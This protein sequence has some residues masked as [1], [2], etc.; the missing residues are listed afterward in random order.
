MCY[1]VMRKTTGHVKEMTIVLLQEMSR[2][3]DGVSRV[4]DLL[5]EKTGGEMSVLQVEG[6]TV[7]GVAAVQ[8]TAMPHGV[9]VRRHVMTGRLEVDR[10]GVVEVVVEMTGDGTTDPAVMTSID[11]S[12][13][14]TGLHE[15][16]TAETVTWTV[17]LR[18]TGILTDLRGTATLTAVI[19]T[20][21]EDRVTET[22]IDHRHVTAI[23]TE[24]RETEILTDATETLTV[25]R[26]IATWTV[27]VAGSETGTSTGRVREIDREILTVHVTATTGLR[28]ILMTVRHLVSPLMTEDAMIVGS[29]TATESE[30]E[31]GELMNVVRLHVTTGDLEV[32]LTVKRGSLYLIVNV[33]SLELFFYNFCVV[34][35]RE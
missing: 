11:V 7:I 18:E 9:E 28:V 12:A 29:G 21:T 14:L 27:T 33:L 3:L 17:V 6:T 4:K 15:T 30:T 13:I 1:L 32:C 19:V 5:P 31:T 10:A 23:S 8:T 2:I 20:L 16:S 22:T 25:H 34:S 26:E 24:V 35:D